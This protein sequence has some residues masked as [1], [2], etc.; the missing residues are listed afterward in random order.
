MDTPS[1]TEGRLRALFA[2]GPAVTSGT[3][4]V[5]IG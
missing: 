5:S 1:V 2:A 4:V 3:T